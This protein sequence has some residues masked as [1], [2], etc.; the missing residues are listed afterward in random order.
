VSLQYLAQ[1]DAASA[2]RVLTGYVHNKSQVSGLARAC[3]LHWKTVFLVE[4]V[5][6][7]A[8]ASGVE[9]LRECQFGPLW[10]HPMSSY[11][12]QLFYGQAVQHSTLQQCA[13]RLSVAFLVLSMGVLGTCL[14]QSRSI[15][16]NANSRRPCERVPHL[17]AADTVGQNA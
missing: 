16:P 12:S 9:S 7:S 2:R 15:T 10:I 8:H 3:V 11:L 1:S 14:P 13:L 17:E 6:V 5:R 4:F